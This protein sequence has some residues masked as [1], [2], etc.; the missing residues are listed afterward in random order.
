MQNEGQIIF[1]LYEIEHVF[2]KD[3][4]QPITVNSLGKEVN[5]SGPFWDM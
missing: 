3:P 1:D 2:L 5:T 4:N